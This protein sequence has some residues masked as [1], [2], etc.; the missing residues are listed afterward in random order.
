MTDKEFDVT[1]GYGFITEEDNEDYF[2]YLSGLRD[3]LKSK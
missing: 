2:V 3:Y 1:K